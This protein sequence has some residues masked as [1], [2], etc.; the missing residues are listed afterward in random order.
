[1]HESQR[2]SGTPPI[3][4]KAGAQ[5]ESPKRTGAG[6]GTFERWSRAIWLRHADLAVAL[7]G[8]ILASALS[9]AATRGERAVTWDEFEYIGLA[10]GLARRFPAHLGG[11]YPFGYPLLAAPLVAFGVHPYVALTTISVIAFAVLLYL[12]SRA[13]NSAARTTSWR[14]F[15]LLLGLVP[16][17]LAM[18][19]KPMAELTFSCLVFLVLVLMSGWSKPA[20]I[21]LTIPFL[22]AA[23]SVRYVGIFLLVAAVGR[24]LFDRLTVR[25][26]PITHAVAAI[27]SAGAIVL[28]LVLSNIVA[29]GSVAGP[30][31]A[32]HYS[33]AGIFQHVYDFGFGVVGLLSEGASV[34]LF[35]NQL[36]RISIGVFFS[37]TIIA[38]CVETLRQRRTALAMTAAIVVLSYFIVLI[39]IQSIVDVFDPSRYLVPVLAPFFVVVA[40]VFGPRKIPRIAAALSLVLIA[41]V[42][43]LRGVNAETD[44]DITAASTFLD[45]RLTRATQVFTNVDALSLAARL[46]TRTTLVEVYPDEGYDFIAK[47]GALKS[48]PGDYIVIGTVR[49]LRRGGTPKFEAGWIPYM[50]ALVRRGVVKIVYENRNAIVGQ[51]VH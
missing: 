17:V 3:A 8:T 44:A 39:A 2:P 14:P 19:L 6:I 48:R 32:G 18:G 51:F 12:I 22:L 46:N 5:Q 11:H 42:T 50:D 36:A 10:W 33:F 28:L 13:F 47:R 20:K 41:A 27:G 45:P 35:E 38:F 40:D 43:A 1:M 29:S 4:G 30:M 23:V 34:R 24:V 7:S 15:A 25:S 31:P 21:Y 49:Y 9:L 26:I 16:F 37:F